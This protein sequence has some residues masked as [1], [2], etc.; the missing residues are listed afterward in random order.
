M[1]RIAFTDCVVQINGEVSQI[2]SDSIGS[3]TRYERI[4]KIEIFIYVHM[5]ILDQ[6]LYIMEV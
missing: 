2:I 4:Y 3:H 5:S 1:A 6:W